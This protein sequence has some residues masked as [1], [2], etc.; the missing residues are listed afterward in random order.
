MPYQYSYSTRSWPLSLTEIDSVATPHVEFKRSFSRLPL[1]VRIWILFEEKY[2]AKTNDPDFAPSVINFTLED[3]YVPDNRSIIQLDT[4]RVP[5]DSLEIIAFA[6][7]ALLPKIKDGPYHTLLL[8]HPSMHV[9]GTFV[10]PGVEPTSRQFLFIPFAS[11]RTGVVWELNKEN[12]PFMV[13]LSIAGPE[14]TGMQA[15]KTDLRE[16][17]YISIYK[18]FSAID[19]LHKSKSIAISDLL[20]E[21]AYIHP[22]K[23]SGQLTFGFLL[24]RIP[25][26]VLSGQICIPFFALPAISC[27]KIKI[28]FLVHCIKQSGLTILEFLE[29]TIYLPVIDFILKCAESKLYAHHLHGQN[30]LID[31]NYT[32]G[33]HSV[34]L[35]SLAQHVRYRDI[36]DLPLNDES[37][38]PELRQ[39]RD[40]T[41]AQS[42]TTTKG[43]HIYAASLFFIRK[44]LVGIVR[45]IL[46]WQKQRFLPAQQLLSEDEMIMGYCES[47]ITVMKSK[48]GHFFINNQLEKYADIQCCFKEMNTIAQYEC[49]FFQGTKRERVWLTQFYKLLNAECHPLKPVCTQG[50]HPNRMIQFQRYLSFYMRDLQQQI[51]GLDMMD[52][53]RHALPYAPSSRTDFVR[54]GSF[55]VQRSHAS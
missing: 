48:S 50:I 27:D 52:A 5:N 14:R 35:L 16:E 34:E 36:A 13:K 7:S 30:F 23:M 45:T 31:I 26:D 21:E 47:L 24:R 29:Q 17:G 54:R 4:Y 3:A 37:M 15:G 41:R 32:T 55:Q 6:D 42:R 51:G 46:N 53:T 49:Q 22:K 39:L 1:S 9:H 43:A 28:P 12:E 40:Q 44:N 8:V 2:N 11:P 18:S 25:A 20:F 19:L 33:S 10:I 38:I